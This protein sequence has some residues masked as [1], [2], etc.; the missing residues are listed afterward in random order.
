MWTSGVAS[1]RAALKV[2]GIEGYEG[3]IVEVT[4]TSTKKTSTERVR[5]HYLQRL[6][7]SDVTRVGS[8][9]TT[10]AIRTLLEAGSVLSQKRLE[11][12]LDSALRQRLTSVERLRAGVW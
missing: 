4:T 1:H 2:L 8:I 6:P 7:S 10:T 11:E 9:P 3:D 5:V 12:A